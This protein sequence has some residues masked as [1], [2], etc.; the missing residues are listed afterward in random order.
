MHI[1]RYESVTTGLKILIVTYLFQ[2]NKIYRSFVPHLFTY[3][4]THMVNAASS[5]KQTERNNTTPLGKNSQ[6]IDASDNGPKERRQREY[7]K[8]VITHAYQSVI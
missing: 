5:S 1:R 4:Q 2:Y 6:S 3:S 7:A 8:N